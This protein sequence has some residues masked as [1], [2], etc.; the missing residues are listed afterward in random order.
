MI[1]AF[2]SDLHIS[3]TKRLSD[4]EDVL[5]YVADYVSTGDVHHLCILGDVFDKRKPT[6]KELKVFNKFLMRVHDKMLGVPGVL[7]LEGNHDADGDISSLTYL[8]DLAVPSVSV[9]KPPYL[10]NG[11]YLDH[12]PLVGAR[13]DNDF[14]MY[15][16][17]DLNEIVASNPNSKVFAFGDF[18]KPQ[19]LK[20]EPLCFYAG[21][22]NKVNFSERNDTKYLWIFDDHTLSKTIPLPCRPMYQYDVHLG[23]DN[24]EYATTPWHCDD[25]SGSLV[26]VVYH[27]TKALLREVKANN[28]HKS[29]RSIGAE[30]VR[31][32]YKITEDSSARD[33][34]I[35]ESV[36]DEQAFTTY[37]GTL[38]D[39]QKVKDAMITS[40]LEI[41]RETKK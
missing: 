34:R 19:V 4:T 10:F 14:E 38:D 23:V 18:H 8:D 41:I 28:I 12:R 27:G 25:L 7:I 17:A 36:T 26:K 35:N 39:T 40:G 32:E 29:L 21:S 11:F 37:V 30:S 31:V 15:S 33:S 2:I 9:V 1:T 16:G 24:S 6:P 20:T 5:S 22:I 13:A 3:E